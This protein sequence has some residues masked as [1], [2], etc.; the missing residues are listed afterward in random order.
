MKKAVLWLSLILFGGGCAAPVKIPLPKDHP[1]HGFYQTANTFNV[2]GQECSKLKGSMEIRPDK[3]GPGR[4]YEKIR[5]FAPGLF[6]VKQKITGRQ[7]VTVIFMEY[8]MVTSIP[9]ACSWDTE[10][11]PLE[12]NAVA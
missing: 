10:Q 9:K 2:S 4:E 7:F 11:F 8:G 12:T 5:E 3:I 6:W 1:A